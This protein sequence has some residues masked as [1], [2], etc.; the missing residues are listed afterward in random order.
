VSDKLATRV[1][2]VDPDRPDP[3]ALDTAAGVLRGGGLVAFATE[4]VYG[5]GGIATDRA[6]VSRIFAAKG[7]PAKNPVIVHVAGIAQ[8]CECVAEWPAEAQRLAERFWPGPLTLVLYRSAIIPDLVTAG[9]DNVAVRA[10]A[11]K[12]ALGLIERSGQPIAAPSA[13]RSNRL[14]PTRAR[15]VLAD[16]DG[17]IDLLID[18]GPT[19]L[20]LESTV[21]DLTTPAPRLL[22]PGPIATKQLEEALE[23]R[24]V[25]E[26]DSSESSDRP[27]SPGQMPIHYAPR[28]PSF[29]ADTCAELSGMGHRESMAVV[30]IG[31]HPTPSLARL[32]PQFVLETPEKASRLLYEIL[33]QC[34]LLGIGSIVVLMP[35][36]LPEW[37]AVRDRLMRATRPLAER[38]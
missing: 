30:V 6:A 27:S 14:S 3:I 13:N 29:R 24:H 16:L 15:H 37:R 4:T 32:A 36:D 25:V 2:V 28:T 10:P 35:P 1:I 33:H 31:E 17:R 22:R 26:L 23:G 5:L 12:V 38:E 19:A 20:G 18:S 21:L 9:G 8:A 34:D 11:A 7:R